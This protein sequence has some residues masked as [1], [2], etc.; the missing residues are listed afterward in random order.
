[1]TYRKL[2]FIFGLLA[3]QVAIASERQAI[4]FINSADHRQAVLIAEINQALFYSPTLRNFVK[5]KVFDINSDAHVF[6]GELDYQTDV[7]GKAVAEYRPGRLPYIFCKHAG[8]IETEFTLSNKD[9]ICLHINK[10]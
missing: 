5:V 6:S 7:G 3:C 4:I 2:F 8:G 10:P 1:M 9:Q